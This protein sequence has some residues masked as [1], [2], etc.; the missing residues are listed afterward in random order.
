[1][2]SW[3]LLA[4]FFRV[5]FFEAII[6][7]FPDGSAAP[8][9]NDFNAIILFTEKLSTFEKVMKLMGEK[10]GSKDSRKNIGLRIILISHRV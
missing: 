7:T 4:F 3:S 6:L 5:D 1:M 2:E 9:F 10:N 8:T